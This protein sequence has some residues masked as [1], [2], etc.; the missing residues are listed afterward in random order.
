MEIPLFTTTLSVSPHKIYPWIVE[1]GNAAADRHG[2]SFL[3][4]D[5]KKKGGF[6][7]SCRKSREHGLTRQDYCGCLY[8]KKE[9]EERRKQG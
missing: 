1:E 7:E 6:Q 3:K 2:V 9:S 4:E 8:S 5:F